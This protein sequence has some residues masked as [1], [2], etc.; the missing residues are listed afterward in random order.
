MSLLSLVEKIFSI[1]DF[2]F[3]YGNKKRISSL[4]YYMLNFTLFY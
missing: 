4:L 1:G 3:K 2:F